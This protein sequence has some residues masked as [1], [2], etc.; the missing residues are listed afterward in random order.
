MRQCRVA[1]FTLV[2]VFLV[3]TPSVTLAQ[4]RVSFPPA[5]SRPAPAAKS[6]PRTATSGEE[7]MFL[8]DAGPTQRKSQVRT[9]PP[10]TNLTVMYKLI[11][12]EQLQYTYPDGKTVKFEQWQSFRNDGHELIQNVNIRLADGN[13]YQYATKPLANPGFDPVDIPLLYMTGDY[14]FEFRDAEVRN[15][16]RFLLDGGTILFNAARGRDEYSHAVIREM[17]RVLPRKPFMKLSPDHPIFNARYRI[18]RALTMVNGMKSTE[19]PVVYAVDIG[20]RA[21]AILIPGG[22]GAAWS[23]HKYHPAGKHLM[24]ESA[25][26]LGVNLVAYVLG[27]TEYGRF[28]AQPFPVYDGRTRSGDVVRFAAVRYAGSWDVNPALQNSL[29]AGLHENTGIDVDYTPHVVDLSDTEIGNFP[30]VFMTGHY[31]F[32]WSPEEIQNL[33]NYLMRGGTLVASAAAGLRPFDIAFRRELKKVFPDNELIKIPPTH[34]LFAL[35]W[36]PIGRVAYTPALLRDDPTLEYPVFYGLFIDQRP[37]VLY[38]PVDFQS[39]LNR[40]SNAYAKGLTSDDAMRVAANIFTFT[41]S[42]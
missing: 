13:N 11:Y 25:R 36:N 18:T 20:T 16:R 19:P 1:A 6:P 9:P 7:T 15:L 41:L 3:A 5:L 22:C 10:P 29:L 38:T 26:R 14:D 17:G 32:E 21:A 42:H 8:N 40:E 31:D 35:G 28:L 34:P 23:G 4:R 37:V 30:L 33:R 24:G 12:G 39:A 27:S 2:C